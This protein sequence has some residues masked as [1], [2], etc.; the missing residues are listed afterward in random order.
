ME[1]NIKSIQK[2]ILVQTIKM[3]KAIDK[4]AENFDK[5][6]ISFEMI[7]ENMVL[8]E[9]ENTTPAF[10]EIRMLTNVEEKTD[11]LQVEKINIEVY[12]Y[13]VIKQIENSSNKICK[14]VEKSIQQLIQ[15]FE[16]FFQGIVK[17]IGDSV[18][19][20]SYLIKNEM[21]KLKGGISELFNCAKKNFEWEGDLKDS[22]TCNCTSNTQK[23]EAVNP[24]P[25]AEIGKWLLSNILEEAI[26]DKLKKILEPMFG[27]KPTTTT[28]LAGVQALF[29][30]K[31]AQSALV[32]MI[33]PLLKMI[34][35]LLKF[36]VPFSKVALP[37][38]A[39]TAA[40]KVGVDLGKE[41]EELLQNINKFG[42]EEGRKA[43]G[44]NVMD[45]VA[46]Y[47]YDT[48]Q[49]NAKIQQVQVDLTNKTASALSKWWEE[50]VSPWFTVEK[51]KEL[52]ENIKKGL[53]TKWEEFTSWWE[54]LGI[55]KWWIEEVAP[56]FTK[57]KWQE[58]GENVKTSLTSK[59]EEFVVWWENTGIYR[60]WAEEVAPWFTVEKWQEIANGMSL[61]ITKK[62]NEVKDWWNK[63][64]NLSEI[65][66]G[67][68]DFVQSV[69][70]ACNQLSEWWEKNKP[71]LDN[72]QLGIKIPKIKIKFDA[73]DIYAKAYQMFGLGG[74]P[75]L[76]TVYDT[77]ATGG[78]PED[79]W[80]RA[81]HGE[82]MGRFDNGQSVVA[83]NM[84]ITE[85]I[86]RGVRNANSEQN[87][88]LREQNA[89]LRQIL[90]KDTGISTRAVFEAVR[91]ENRDYINRN[92][93]SAFAF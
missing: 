49:A 30:N 74:R 57:E 21:T 66:V 3:N 26:S 78:F 92:G 88:L 20:I 17:V 93:E 67:F 55:Y 7:T 79:G 64:G 14:S 87:A 72:L 44:N 1:E 69:K 25:L 43:S 6:I 86:A 29:G 12:F 27:T 19:S 71:S 62:W 5:L 36:V 34:A 15:N 46:L 33:E 90:A 40:M 65:K 47:Q 59:W 35:P 54:D 24:N 16:K 37:M 51:W 82:I 22:L 31:A 13:D 77:F 8:K 38:L 52:G 89:L 68:T 85:G 80:F 32:F 63:K 75:I 91:S 42:E 28:L 18:N 53:T 10:Y 4:L 48:E 11:T 61:G 39:A 70:T 9:F 2:E 56:W 83:N 76:Y 58:L 84:Q 81:S 45:K 50:E 41:T 73:D 60:W 23:N